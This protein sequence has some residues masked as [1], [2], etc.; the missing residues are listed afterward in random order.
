MTGFQFFKMFYDLFHD[1]V[2]D[3]DASY[4]FQDF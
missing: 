1:F 2:F 3:R 4:S